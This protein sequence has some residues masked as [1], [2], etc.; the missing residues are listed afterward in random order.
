MGNVCMKPKT[1]DSNKAN[2]KDYKKIIKFDEEEKEFGGKAST[3]YADFENTSSLV[4][5]LKANPD[6]KYLIESYLECPKECNSVKCGQCTAE[7][8]NNIKLSLERCNNLKKHLQD[9][10]CKNFIE[11]KAWGCTNPDI[12]KDM[13]K[14]SPWKAPPPTPEPKVISFRVIELIPH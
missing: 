7:H 3:F 12:K 9:Q 6:L 13:M 5:F 14:M 4:P 10:G 1:G 8:C 2:P 11:I